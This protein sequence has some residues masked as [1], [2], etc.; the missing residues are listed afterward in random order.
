M[1][2]Y[3]ILSTFLEHLS[4]NYFI[5]LMGFGAFAAIWWIRV[6]LILPASRLLRHLEEVLHITKKV[7]LSSQ[8]IDKISENS[9]AAMSDRIYFSTADFGQ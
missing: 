3:S 9:K 4:K 1:A 5:Y 7:F 6:V 8:M 2:V